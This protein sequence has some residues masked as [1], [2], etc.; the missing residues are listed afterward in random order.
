MISW[1][2]SEVAMLEAVVDRIIPHDQDAGA[3]A[4][5]AV[6]FVTRRLGREPSAFVE[7][8]R[9]GLSG[10]EQSAKSLLGRPFGELTPA[11]RDRV[12]AQ[13]QDDAWFRTLAEFTAE[14]FYADPGNG[15]NAGALSWRMVGYDPR[16]PERATPPKRVAAAEPDLGGVFDAIV[17][18]AGAGG[19][20]VACLLAEAGHRV[21]L[22][23]RGRDQG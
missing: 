18:G 7:V 15:G 17:V 22:L 13:C 8:V 3:L 19:G 4:T 16:L 9:V 6:R 5:G 23:E 10:V 21:L 11:D 2:A 12:L 1:S 20:I 14:G